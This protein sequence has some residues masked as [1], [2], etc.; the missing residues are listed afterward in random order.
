MKLVVLAHAPES[1]EPAEGALDD[2]TAR[3]NLE[4]T[5]VVGPFHDLQLDRAKVAPEVSYP[6]DKLSGVA[7]V[8]PDVAQAQE[9]VGETGEQE[10]R[11][12]TILNVRGMDD[13]RQDE[14][15]RVDED[16]SLA[17]TD[18]LARIVTA[19]PPSLS[20]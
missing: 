10:L 6:L 8:R 9:G 16:V 12:V 20:S 4:A 13:D 2:P 19:R 7:A 1:S 18:F 11:A 14:T 17:S 3:Q 5:D 15:E